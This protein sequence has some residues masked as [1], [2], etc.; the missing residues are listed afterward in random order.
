MTATSLLQ[1]SELP[2]I[3]QPQPA[4]AE[5]EKEQVDGRGNQCYRQ[6]RQAAQKI[7]CSFHGFDSFRRSRVASSSANHQPGTRSRVPPFGCSTGRRSASRGS[8]P[9][10]CARFRPCCL[11]VAAAVEEEPPQE[12]NHRSEHTQTDDS[13]PADRT[14]NIIRLVH[15]RPLRSVTVDRCTRANAKLSIHVI[16]VRLEY[17]ASGRWCQQSANAA[18]H[19]RSRIRDR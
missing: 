13:Q 1:S 16:A 12:I 7:R 2:L 3:Q 8:V 5:D 15:V 14:Q 18:V 9:R 10:Q 4:P 6:C 11:V 17:W 19:S